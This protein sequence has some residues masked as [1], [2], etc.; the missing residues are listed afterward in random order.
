VV[1]VSIGQRLDIRTPWFE[2]G[3][4]VDLPAGAAVFAPDGRFAGLT[5]AVDGG[6]VIIPGADV[7]GSAEELAAKVKPAGTAPR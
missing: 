2:P 3:E 5:A 4:T 6:T 1:A 7:L